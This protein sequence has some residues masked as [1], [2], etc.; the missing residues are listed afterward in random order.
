[1]CK[2][3]NDKLVLDHISFNVKQGEL[4]GYI[5]PNGAGK[6]TTINI[7]MGIVE[8]DEGDVYILGEKIGKKN[9]EI[10]RRLGYVP[11]TPYMYKAL[12]PIE[13]FYFIG[14]MYDIDR[15]NLKKRIDYYV[16]FFELGDF[17]KQL[18]H[19]LSK[20]NIQKTLIISGILHDPDIYIFDE[21][22]NGLDVN[23]QFR[24]KQLL[25]DLI[26]KGKTVL[27]SSHIVEI[28]EKLSKNIIVLDKGKI[29]Y[30]GLLRDLIK[31]YKK[32]NLEEVL[33]EVLNNDQ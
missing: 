33:L 17:T 24:F 10:K 18:I 21:P 23:G 32:E 26:K 3:Y 16:E 6:T 27:Y 13:Y 7:I 31:N 11:E 22:I 30:E 2:S 12:T 1:M 20:G 19:T 9:L 25:S 5:G 8:K 4:T 29:K 28:V 14:T 15:E